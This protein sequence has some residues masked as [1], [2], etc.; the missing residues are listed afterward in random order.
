MRSAGVGALLL[1]APSLGHAR[2]GATSQALPS[3]RLSDLV[4]E[5]GGAVTVSEDVL[6]DTSVTLDYL[7]IESGG[8]LVFDPDTS[9]TLQLRG[10]AV[11]GGRL[12][13]APASAEVDHAL[14]FVDVN[15]R[16]FVGGG[17]TPLDSDVG[18]WVVDEGQLDLRGTPKTAWV[19]AADS[20]SAGSL[21]LKLAAPPQ[22]WEVGDELVVCPTGSPAV[23][24]SST[25]FSTGRIVA[26][27]DSTVALDQPVQFDHPTVRLSDDVIASAE[28]LNLSRNVRVE[29]TATGRAH[30]FVHAAAPQLVAYTAIRH[31]GP[32]HPQ[33]KFTESVL[34]RYGLHFHMAVDASRGT[35][36]TG[37][38]VREAG[39]HAFVPHE[40]HGITFTSCISHATMD[41][42]YWWDRASDV[43]EPV[44]NDAH[45]VACIASLVTV[46]PSFRGFK[47]A[48]FMLGDGAGNEVRDCVAVGVQGNVDAAGFVWPSNSGRIQTWLFESNVTHN[49]ACHGA[50]VWQ[51]TNARHQVRRLA[52][53]HNGAAG[54]SL[55][56]YANQ[57]RFFQVLAVGNGGPGLLLHAVSR[58]EGEIVLACSTIDCGGLAEFAIEDVRHRNP[59]VRAVRVRD[60]VLLGYTEAAVGVRPTGP[61]Q[62]E[63]AWVDLLRCDVAGRDVWFSDLAPIA[64]RVR[65]QT[66]SGTAIVTAPS[67]SARRGSLDEDRNAVVAS[68][69]P[70][71]ATSTIRSRGGAGWDLSG[72]SPAPNVAPL[73]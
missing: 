17:M 70:F 68:I 15:E 36:V 62:S 20:I 50:F 55:G 69:E 56:A 35:A 27:S 18:M 49:N 24:N 42:A 58:H 21:E 65:I 25:A 37:V 64:S 41:D 52:T 63:R 1:A 51:N 22:G 57:Y 34:G 19:R 60:S 11:V 46:D 45:F 39:A 13:M 30:V 2:T 72:F 14:V 26:V 5:Q 32:R 7:T 12:E 38:V 6:V 48:G 16:A 10:N 73:P 33:D 67:H 3:R 59:A 43:A 40:S 71:G 31:V 66:P 23:S 9:A 4:A 54:I 53:Y 8:Y 44:T 47:M 29:G 28:V 61:Q